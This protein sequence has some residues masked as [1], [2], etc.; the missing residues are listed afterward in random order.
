MRAKTEKRK[1]ENLIVSDLSP[2][3]PRY[4]LRVMLTPPDKNVTLEKLVTCLEGISERSGGIIIAGPIG[5]DKTQVIGIKEGYV[6]PEINPRDLQAMAWWTDRNADYVKNV[7]PFTAGVLEHSHGVVYYYPKDNLIDII[8]ETCM[9]LK[10]EKVYGFLDVYWQPEEGK[11]QSIFSEITTGKIVKT[12]P[13]AREMVLRLYS[14]INNFGKEEKS[15]DQVLED[16]EFLEKSILT[17]KHSKLGELESYFTETQRTIMWKIYA[18]YEG[19]LEKI[20][21]KKIISGEAKNE[22]IFQVYGRYKRLND[23]E[24]EFGRISKDTTVAFIGG[25]WL[26]ISAINYARAG[27]K[28]TVYEKDEKRIDIAEQV[29]NKLGLSDSIHY[30]CTKAEDADFHG[31]NYEVL[32][33]AAMAFPKNKI[34]NATITYHRYD[35]QRVIMR[36]TS[37]NLSYLYQE[38]IPETDFEKI[39]LPEKFY[40]ATRNEILSFLVLSRKPSIWD[41]VKVWIKEYN[42]MMDEFKRIFH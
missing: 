2:N 7:S 31:T 40:K 32:V 1:T 5:V 13:E 24:I 4:S 14:I 18:K 3:L 10:P 41:E 33:I 42:L 34:I 23:K 15:I 11:M 17:H 37:Q 30:I 19:E 16:G 12:F 26:P 35:C 36:T 8:I 38:L 29:T 28:V 9:P 6:H 22:N 27:A 20:A 39:V 21:A 25:G